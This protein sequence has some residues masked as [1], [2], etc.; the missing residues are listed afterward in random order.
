MRRSHFLFR[1]LLGLYPR[2]FR[3]RFGEEMESTFVAA[4]AEAQKRGFVVTTRLWIKTLL[5]LLSCAVAERLRTRRMSSR[6][7][8]VQHHPGRRGAGEF[9]MSIVRDLRFGARS[10]L[11]RPL[12]AFA[13]ILTLG[14]GIG[15]NTAVV[16]AVHGVMW[17]PL[18]YESPEELVVLWPDRSFSTR[19]AVFLREHTRMLEGVATVAGW[20]VALT[21]VPEPTQLRGARTSANVFTLLGVAPALGRTFVD[22]DVAVGARPVVMLSH[23]T[24]AS[25]FGSDETLVGR[26]LMIDGQAHEVVGVMPPSFEIFDPTTEVWIPLVEDPT[27]WEYTGNVSLAFGRLAPGVT[28]GAAQGEFAQLIDQMREA[29]EY[30]DDFGPGATLAGFKESLVGRYRVMFLVLLGAVGFILLIAASNLSNLLLTKAV[31]RRQEMAMRTALGATRAR[32][33]QVVLTESALLSVAGALVGLALAFGGVALLKQLVPAATP[34]A[35]AIAVDG[36]VLLACLVFA[37]GAGLLF[38]IAPA[39]IMT[40]LNL[41]RDV[42]GT[43]GSTAGGRGNNRLRQALVVIQVAL[44]VVLVVG[45]GVMIRSISELASVRPGFEYDHVLTLRLFP[46][47]PSYDTPVEYHRFYV[48][49]IERVEAIPGVQSAGAVQ[50]LPLS[51]AGWG[52]PVEIEG[53]PVPEGQ[54]MP[55]SGWRIVSGHYFQ[56]MGIRLLEGRVFGDQD[57]ESSELVT[58]VNETF[59]RRFWPGE[60]AIGHRLKHGRDSATWVTV[61]GVVEDVSHFSLGQEPALELYRPHAQS[62]MP[63]LMLAVRTTGD[64]ATLARR[65]TSEVWSVDP[66]V[67]IS[68]VTPLA[69]VVAASYSNS[70]LLMTLLTIFAAVALSLGAIGVYGVTSFAVSR[71]T[72]EIGVRMAL[73]ASDGRVRMEVLRMGVFNALGGTVLGLAGAWALSRFLEGLVFEVSATDPATFAA[74]AM[75]IVVV[76]AAASYLPA[77]RATKIDPAEALRTS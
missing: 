41:Q 64:P 34:R 68:N 6:H 29:L 1:F 9:I 16:S 49:L 37:V 33:L 14:L 54:S 30:P 57:D 32:L 71:R 46:V 15:A 55:I 8:A 76:A 60:S 7:Y 50:H 47:G 27:R 74:V 72:N 4:H 28:L 12:F 40:Q 43:R 11:R 19:E 10:L 58:I 77:R 26:S 25:R 23:T 70:R 48:D 22:E 21:D 17:R 5:E 45:A 44:A 13:A 31:D 2:S 67:P 3:R 53:Q 39:A 51:G 62:T 75:V 66:N 36:S 38:S 56:S 20:S 69:D 52:T 35:A 42:G 59:A 65:I 61:V 63:A 18:A 24:W 73:G